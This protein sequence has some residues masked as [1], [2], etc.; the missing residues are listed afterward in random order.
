MKEGG[1]EVQL[2]IEEAGVVAHRI[3]GGAAQWL[4]PLAR[5]DAKG[6]GATPT[7]VVEIERAL[8]VPNPSGRR[9][10]LTNR[11]GESIVTYTIGRQQPNV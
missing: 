5:D 2:T 6:R 9:A 10:E 1:R 11:E 8:S 7:E 4:I 3:L